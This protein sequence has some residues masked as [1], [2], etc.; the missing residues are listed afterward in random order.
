[1][2]PSAA[3]QITS[4][5]S[6]LEA[7]SPYAAP[8]WVLPARRAWWGAGRSGPEPQD[9]SLGLPSF[10]TQSGTGKSCLCCGLSL[11]GV[12][13]KDVQQAPS[14][15]VPSA[16]PNLPPEPWAAFLSHQDPT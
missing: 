9:L 8:R 11:P 5:R 15:D 7:Q 6:Q 10:K 12:N 4:G 16:V 2:P 13:D 1:M 14:G 3:P